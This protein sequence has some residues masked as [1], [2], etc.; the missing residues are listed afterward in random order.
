MVYVPEAHSS[1]R[2]SISAADEIERR[3]RIVAG[4][5]Q[6]IARSADILPFK[7]PLWVWQV[8]SHKYLRP[9]VPFFM[10]LAFFSAL[11]S[12]FVPASA[13]PTWFW[14]TY[15]WNWIILDAQILFYVVAWLGTKL[16]KKGKLGKL[17][18][19]ATFLVNSNFAALRGFWR[20]IRKSQQTQWK[21]AQRRGETT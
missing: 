7:R 17:L 9:L 6:A 21:R 11:V 3:T 1:E 4:R 19:F 2:V 18:Y 12:V 20:Y 8:I 14:L 5:Y 13:K 16:G 10:I 15:P